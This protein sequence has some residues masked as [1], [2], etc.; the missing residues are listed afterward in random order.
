[1]GG[2]GADDVEPGRVRNERI[3]QGTRRWRP[4]T[5]RCRMM[6]RLAF[7]VSGTYLPVERDSL[8]VHVLGRESFATLLVQ[9]P[10]SVGA[11]S[12]SNRISLF[13]VGR[14]GREHLTRRQPKRL[15]PRLEA[16]RL[17]QKLAAIHL[18]QRGGE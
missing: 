7:L 3:S 8:P 1:V 18:A 14:R 16:V 15:A 2:A 6:R 9:A 4:G 5:R 10:G 13:L 12:P 11:R 17:R